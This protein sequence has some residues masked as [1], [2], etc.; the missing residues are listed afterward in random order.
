MKN[1]EPTNNK[2]GVLSILIYNIYYTYS[3]CLGKLSESVNK[4]KVFQM[5]SNTEIG[6]T[7]NRTETFLFVLTVQN[8]GN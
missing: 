4:L 2:K 5:H 7:L 1:E 3:D 6:A 8:N